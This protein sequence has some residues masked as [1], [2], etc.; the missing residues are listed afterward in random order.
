MK[1]KSGSLKKINTIYKPLAKMRKI[2]REKH[3]SK[4]SGIK[5]GI[6]P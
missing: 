3:N 5:K 6:F 4:I 1:Q 2:K